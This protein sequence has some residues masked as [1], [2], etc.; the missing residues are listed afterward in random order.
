MG[1][2]STLNVIPCNRNAIFFNATILMAE[3]SP[4][5]CTMQSFFNAKQ[6]TRKLIA[7]FFKCKPFTMHKTFWMQT[8]WMQTFWMHTF[9]MQTIL[10]ANHFECN[11]FWMQTILIA[12]HFVCK[13]FPMQILS[14]IVWWI[15]LGDMGYFR[16]LTRLL[17]TDLPH[18]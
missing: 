3:I 1:R 5:T 8:I 2:I 17:K 14:H 11:L 4:Q 12:N 6:S 13:P 15:Y 16:N 7:N 9:W 10:N 18:L